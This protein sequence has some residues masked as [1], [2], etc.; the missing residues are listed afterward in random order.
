MSAVAIICRWKWGRRHFRASNYEM[1]SGELAPRTPSL[2]PL[3][4]TLA[5]V[6]GNSWRHPWVV[7]Q[8]LY[9]PKIWLYYIS[10][11]SELGL[12]M[13]VTCLAVS[14]LSFNYISF[15][16]SSLVVSQRMWNICLSFL[17]QCVENHCIC[18][19][20][21]HCQLS[22]QTIVVQALMISRVLLAN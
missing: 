12:S 14:L 22:E 10:L 1:F 16:L 2:V 4:R 8:C 6:S 15:K 7:L 13:N 5:P 9:L 17:N 11:Y 3:S 21:Q 18:S 20:L 19:C